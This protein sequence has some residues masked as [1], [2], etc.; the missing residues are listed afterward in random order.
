MGGVPWASVHPVRLRKSQAELT[1]PP[2]SLRGKCGLQTGVLSAEEPQPS[3][4]FFSSHCIVRAR[5]SAG[6]P[7]ALAE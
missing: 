5:V 7:G 4:S 3:P 2:D 1:V 6:V